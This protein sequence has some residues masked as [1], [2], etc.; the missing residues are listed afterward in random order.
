MTKH[1]TCPK[2][3]YK[4]LYWRVT[5]DNYKCTKCRCLF[6]ISFKEL[7]KGSMSDEQG[8]RFILKITREEGIINYNREYHLEPGK[9]TLKG[10]YHKLNWINCAYPDRNSCNWEIG[11]DRCEYMKNVSGD[12]KCMCPEEQSPDL[13]NQKP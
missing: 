1:K 9:T 10:R 13:E 3:G 5:D 7:L 12:W 6:D 2:C 4:S 8:N 11:S